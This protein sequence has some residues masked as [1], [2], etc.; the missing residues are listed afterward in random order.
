MEICEEWFTDPLLSD[1][2]F[3]GANIEVVSVKV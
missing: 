3:F 2:C 1:L